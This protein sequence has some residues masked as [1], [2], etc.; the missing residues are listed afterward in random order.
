M[1]QQRPRSIGKLQS[2]GQ[3]HSQK[4][5]R[6]AV[7]CVREVRE[8]R[9][10]GGGQNDRRIFAPRKNMTIELPKACMAGNKFIVLNLG[11]GAVPCPRLPAS[12]T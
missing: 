3:M 1:V 9:G 12:G 10:S 2:K 8:G 5:V 7:M 11:L 6:D 4:R